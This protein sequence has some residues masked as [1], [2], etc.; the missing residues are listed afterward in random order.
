M[1][2]VPQPWH[3]Q[4]TNEH[5]VLLAVNAVRPDLFKSALYAMVDAQEDF[6]D[7]KSIDKSRRQLYKELVPIALSGCASEAERADV[8]EKVHKLLDEKD[9]SRIKLHCRYHRRLGVHVTPTVFLNGEEATVVSS[10]WTGEQ[11][12]EFLKEYGVDA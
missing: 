3:S 6:F 5:E 8:S 1:V 12:I 10:S 7:A 9:D 11:W 4:S 2:S